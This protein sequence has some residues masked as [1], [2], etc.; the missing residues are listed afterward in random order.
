MVNKKVTEDLV[1]FRG[2]AVKRFQIGEVL[3]SFVVLGS[4]TLN[5]WTAKGFDPKKRMLF[6]GQRESHSV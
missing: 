5:G 6:P 3:R 2:D 4:T 1:K